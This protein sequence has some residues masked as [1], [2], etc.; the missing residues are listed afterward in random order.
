MNHTP[1]AADFRDEQNGL[2]LYLCEEF[3]YKDKEFENVHLHDSTMRNI[4]GIMEL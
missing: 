1:F 4:I 2:I 3:Q